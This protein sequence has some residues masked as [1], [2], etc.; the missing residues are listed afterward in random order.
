MGFT[1]AKE[2]M[3]L[4]LANLKSGIPREE[5]ARLSEIWAED[6]GSYDID[7]IIVE[8]EAALI[9]KTWHKYHIPRL[10]NI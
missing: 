4:R 3:E 6:L 1:E 2:W 10:W 7:P 5:R 9:A 8:M